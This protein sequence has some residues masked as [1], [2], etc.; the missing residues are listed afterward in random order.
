MSTMKKTTENYNFDD[1][2]LDDDFVRSVND[3]SCAEDYI[4]RLKVQYPNQEKNIDLALEVLSGIENKY[5]AST[6]PQ[7]Q[8][9]W[10]GIASVFAE[11]ISGREKASDS[12]TKKRSLVY[13]PLF[14]IAA[15]LILLLGI[16]C[17]IHLGNKK[18][19]SID[20]FAASNKVNLEKSQLILSNGEKIEVPAGEAKI[21]YSPDGASV[22][23]NDSSDVI[24][25]ARE[26]QFNQ[27]TVPY[28][29]YVSLQLSDGTK[30]WLNSGSRMIYPP[31]FAEKQREVYLQGEGYFEVTQNAQKPFFVKTDRMRVEVL[32]TKF[33]V[34]A[35]DKEN[36]YSTLLLEGTVSLSTRQKL[37]LNHDDI[38]LKPSERGE[39]SQITS[40]FK[41]EKIDH[42]ANYIAWMYGYLNF[43]D[44]ALE[45]LIKRVSRYY[46]IDIQIKSDVGEFKISGKLDLKN[47]PERVL[48][49]IAV[50][51]NQ[52][53]TKQEGGFTISN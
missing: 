29:K 47:D 19:L 8:K 17:L 33:D 10:N 6:Q 15:G 16:G 34:Q 48:K 26:E 4:T 49:G 25:S 13:N 31:V 41:V 2:L 35:F 50:I 24:Q 52:K 51:A 39:L 14:R 46:N 27:I 9:I 22:K 44:E 36:S 43:E 32:G 1:F 37:R 5:I 18:D 53:V 21:S 40:Q 38:L 28:G 7:R 11:S 42:P 12:N 45:S 23:I 30:V 20:R 3:L